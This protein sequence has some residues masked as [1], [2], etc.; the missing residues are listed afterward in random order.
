MRD[1]RK[2]PDAWE[3]SEARTGLEP[4]TSGVTV[5]QPSWPA[6]HRGSQRLL[7]IE[8]TYERQGTASG[9]ARPA[10]PSVTAVTYFLLH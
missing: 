8:N 4:V 1:R 10:A 7:T 6:L 2:A 9:H 5:G 3:I